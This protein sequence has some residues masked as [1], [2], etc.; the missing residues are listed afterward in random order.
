M[1]RTVPAFT[2]TDSLSTSWKGSKRPSGPRR[3]TDCL[4]TV[5]LPFLEWLSVVR[6][7]FTLSLW[8]SVVDVQDWFPSTVGESEVCAQSARLKQKYAPITS[9]RISPKRGWSDDVMGIHQV[10]STP[11]LIHY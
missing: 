2:C 4:S 8:D 7:G 1:V 6:V 5:R 3:C 10:K 9:S 11:S